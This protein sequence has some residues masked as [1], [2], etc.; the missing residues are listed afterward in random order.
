ME[1]VQAERP[2]RPQGDALRFRLRDAIPSDIPY[3]AA[4][5]SEQFRAS[6][7]ELG[8]L[9]HGTFKKWV[10][11][12]IEAALAAS[13]VRVAAPQDV[14]DDITVYGFRV[15]D[16]ARKLIHMVYVQHKLRRLG[17]ARALTA[18]LRLSDYDWTTP[19]SA[20]RVWIAHKYRLGAYR[21]FFLEE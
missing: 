20:L 8:R 4:T 10:V 17:I 3:V 16:H 2:L 5:W 15:V 19:T 11:P 7:Y 18:D 6:S 1:A 14:S 12:R 13:E 9:R 21:P